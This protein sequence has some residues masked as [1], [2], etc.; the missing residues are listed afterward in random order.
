MMYPCNFWFESYKGY[1]IK[2][3][4]SSPTEEIITVTKDLEVLKSFKNVQ[5][6]SVKRYIRR[7]INAE[8]VK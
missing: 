5:L 8:K 7:K 2:G 3:W 1:H 4:F 6:D